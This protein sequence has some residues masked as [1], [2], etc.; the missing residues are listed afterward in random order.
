MNINLHDQ[1]EELQGFSI[2]LKIDSNIIWTIKLHLKKW[3]QG[4][5][6]NV[7]INCGA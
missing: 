2:I 7:N 1:N 4:M 3:M 5:Q 6:N